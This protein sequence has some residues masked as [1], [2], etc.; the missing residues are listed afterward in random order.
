MFDVPLITTDVT[1]DSMWNKERFRTPWNIKAITN[2]IDCTLVSFQSTFYCFKTKKWVTQVTRSKTE[3]TFRLSWRAALSNKQRLTQEQAF[4]FSSA[5]R[6]KQNNESDTL[7]VRTKG[8][9]DGVAITSR[10]V[11]PRKWATKKKNTSTWRRTS[12]RDSL[13]SS[14]PTNTGDRGSSWREGYLS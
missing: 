6:W 4:V 10:A 13:F 2:K 8:H 12:S 1:L 3:A 9:R 7:G 11:E 5:F 14:W